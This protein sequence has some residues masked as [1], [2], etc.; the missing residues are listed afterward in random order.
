MN[1]DI[2]KLLDIGSYQA[3]MPLNLNIDDKYAVKVLLDNSFNMQS[4]E[5]LEKIGFSY[6]ILKKKKVEKHN[7]KGLKLKSFLLN[8]HN[9]GRTIKKRENCVINYIWLKKVQV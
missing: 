9:G 8:K 3:K 2:R 5:V 1:D 7:M 4:G 6:I